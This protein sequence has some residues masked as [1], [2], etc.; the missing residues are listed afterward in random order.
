MATAA[1]CLVLALTSHV[2]QT[3]RRAAAMLYLPVDDISPAAASSVE[4][5]G[6]A[7]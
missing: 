1:A 5:G 7:R 4:G 3:G 6:K 2:Q